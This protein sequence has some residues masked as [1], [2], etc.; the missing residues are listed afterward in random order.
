[1]NMETYLYNNEKVDLQLSDVLFRIIVAKKLNKLTYFYIT[2]LMGVIN[3]KI[4]FLKQ[5]IIK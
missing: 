4:K 5:I 2:M 1:M 3:F